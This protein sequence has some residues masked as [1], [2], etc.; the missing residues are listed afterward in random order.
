[1]A[2]KGTFGDSDKDSSMSDT[3]M[4]LAYCPFPPVMKIYYQW[5]PAGLTTFFVCGA[6]Q[7]DRLFAIKLHTG[8]SLSEPLGVKQG[9]HLYNGPTTNDPLLAAAGDDS[10]FRS[11]SMSNNSRVF[12]PARNKEGLTQEMMRAYITSDKHVAFSFSIEIGFGKKLHREIFEWRNINKNERDESTEHGGFRL[13]RLSP[14]LEQ[15]ASGG[16]S[17]SQGIPTSSTVASQDEAVAIFGWRSFWTSPKHPLDLRLVG[18]GLTGELGDRWTLMVLI[19]ALRLWELHQR[20]KTQRA[21][22]AVAEKVGAKE[23]PVH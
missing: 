15:N 1:M 21:P 20:G 17:S 7:Q 8:Y 19:T 16:E 22:V 6:N 4:S 9:L 11:F 10:A 5:K 12:L 18:A 14:N 3:P 23:K 2:D 13:F